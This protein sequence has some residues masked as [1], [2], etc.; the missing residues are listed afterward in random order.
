[1]EIC[2]TTKKLR[3]VQKRPG[4]ARTSSPLSAVEGK[5]QAAVQE[6]RRPKRMPVIRL[7]AKVKA[8]TLVSTPTLRSMETGTR[9]GR[10]WPRRRSECRVRRRGEKEEWIRRGLGEG[11]ARAWRREQ[12]GR[13]FRAAV[14]RLA[15]GKDWLR[16]RRR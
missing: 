16:C 2:A 4:R 12:C 7:S 8:R 9:R 13:P 11:V 14:L 6:G 5:R 3:R 15:R 10:W 1:M